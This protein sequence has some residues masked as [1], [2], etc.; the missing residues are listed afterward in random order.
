[1]RMST[2]IPQSE[3]DFV[4]WNQSISP[5]KQG[6]RLNPKE[7]TKKIPKQLGKGL[8]GETPILSREGRLGAADGSFVKTP[9]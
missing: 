5:R 6:A 7:E 3:G 4:L 2:D 8:F 1:M 9:A